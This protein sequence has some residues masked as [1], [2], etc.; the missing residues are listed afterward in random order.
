MLIRESTTKADS[1]RYSIGD[2]T[3]IHVFFSAFSLNLCHFETIGAL[4][5]CVLHIVCRKMEHFQALLYT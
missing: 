1:Y 5:F 4:L 3:H 2:F